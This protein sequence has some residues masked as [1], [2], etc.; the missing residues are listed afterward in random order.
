MDIGGDRKKIKIKYKMDLLHFPYSGCGSSPTLYPT[1][2]EGILKK[3]EEELKK[4]KKIERKNG[5]EQ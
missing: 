5:R 3:E 4:K 1:T 2:L